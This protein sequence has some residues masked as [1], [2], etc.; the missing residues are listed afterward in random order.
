MQQKW[1]EGG[2][3]PANEQAV[4]VL[5]PMSAALTAPLLPGTCSGSG[6]PGSSGT[7]SEGHRAAAECHERFCR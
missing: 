7:P 4:I 6:I 3:P 5:H 2:N 1:T